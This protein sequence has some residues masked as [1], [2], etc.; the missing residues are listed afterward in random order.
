MLGAEMIQLVK[1]AG[2]MIRR[3]SENCLWFSIVSKTNAYR[4]S[5]TGTTAIEY[6][7]IIGGIAVAI[8]TIVFNLGEDLEAFFNEVQNQ[9]FRK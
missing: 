8:L 1:I 7:L 6:G 9:L 5:A 3:T 4:H 2:R